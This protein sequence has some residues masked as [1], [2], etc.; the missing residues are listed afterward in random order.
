M[1]SR[2]FSVIINTDNRA[3][4]LGHTLEGLRHLDHPCFEVIVVRGPTPDATDDVLRAYAGAIKVGHCPERNLSQSRNIGI[5]LATGEIV[6]FIDDDAYPDPEWLNRLDEA[7]DDP[8]TVG[9]GGPV[10]DWTGARLQV[11][12]SI[13]NR[14]GD[15][16]VENVPGFDLSYLLARPD[17]SLFTYP[18]GTN[19]S[20]LRHRVIE[21]G[22]FDEQFEYGWDDV[23]LC[24][25]FIDQGW[26]VRVIEDGY[27]YHKSLPS[28]IRGENRAT[29]NMRVLLKNKAYYTYKHGWGVVPLSEIATSLAD[30]AEHYRDEISR[31]VEKGLLGPAELE[32]YEEDVA[33]GFDIGYAVWR[34]GRDRRRAPGWF[35]Q[36]EQPFVPF[37]TLRARADKLHLCFFTVEYPPEPLNGIGR[38]VHGLATGLGRLGHEVHVVTRGTEL[39]RVDLEDDVWVHRVVPRPHLLPEGISVPQGLWDY[40]AT[41]CD[42][43]LRIH[44]HRPLDLVQAP[45]WSTEGIAVLVDGRLPLVVGLYTPLATVA[46][47]DTPIARGIAAGEP[48]VP[49]LIELERLTYRRAPHFLACGR[50]VVDE[51][52]SAYGVTLGP[53]RVG[54][55]P[56]GIEDRA[57]TVAPEHRPGRVEVLFVGR[58]E[59]RKGIDTLLAAVPEVVR[60]HPEVGFTIV[61]EDSRPMTDGR[62]HRQR[63]EAS[64]AWPEVAANVRFLGRVDD[65]RLYRLYAGCDVFVAP[66][67]FESFGLILLEAMMFAKAVVATRVGG[68][69]EIVSDGETGLLVPPGDAGALGRAIASLVASPARRNE[70]G[71]AARRRFESVYRQEAMVEGVNR[72]F[73]S[74]LGRTTAEPSV[75][76]VSVPTTAAPE[77]A[78]TTGA[79]IQPPPAQARRA[80]S[81]TPGLSGPSPEVVDRLTCPQCGS[82]VAVDALTVTEGGDVKTGR[83]R[84]TGEDR[85]VGSI[86]HFK[87]DFLDDPPA[88]RIPERPLVVAEVGERRIAADGPGVGRQ[89][90]W[91]PDGTGSLVSAGVIGDA[92]V[93]EAE[94]T[95]LVVRMRCQPTGG[96]VD[97]FIDGVPATTV[98][99]YQAEGSQN[100][101]VRVVTDQPLATREVAVRARGQAH[102]DSIGRTVLVEGFVLY[103]PSGT[104]TGFGPPQPVNRGNPYSP[105]LERWL[106]TIRAGQP[107]LEF[108]GGDRRRCLPGHLNIEY[109]KFELA[110]GF[111]DVHAIPFADDTFAATW[112][113]A[114]FEH[115]DD[116]FRAARELIRVTRPGGLVMT[117]VAF[118]QPLHAV[119]Y[120][121]FNMTTWGLQA[122]FSSCEILECDWFGDLSTTVEWLAQSVNLHTK[123]DPAEL[124][125]IVDKFRSYD[126]LVSHA[127]LRAAASAVYLIARKPG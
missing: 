54:L 77:P 31:H 30:Y 26:V 44:Q 79:A 33:A 46:S 4:S 74:I 39:D 87:Y 81:P 51:I 49:S 78:S 40:A 13:S 59:D 104:D 89:G 93:L 58:L 56:H 24:H 72:Y 23:D 115:I 126:A 43:A 66:S 20:F 25:R 88:V 16:W 52:E 32:Q 19:A 41:L 35:A 83:L 27:V 124:A 34:E 111:A 45:N 47:V 123:V 121:F 103:G 76:P 62:T 117:E 28:A 17:T 42:E 105:Y 80:G 101:A 10:W 84:C 109:L 120:H 1:S 86:E 100:L 94:L 6:A 90:A 70:L 108:G 68:M 64:S 107:V 55:V 2:R 112:T 60:A 110:D 98:D 36:N 82:P 11:L 127:E 29:H 97:V 63:F 99:L 5:G 125:A 3:E 102:A 22:G 113:Q 53:E 91:V 9:A 38:V 12:Y 122:L 14:L 85:V 65:D 106:A 96:I 57:G 114:V 48:E 118:M 73:D 71:S 18:I 116:P 92:L 75:H 61:G 95:D 37:P 7:Y 50:S 69:A 119:P 8:E 15:V 21:I 67:R